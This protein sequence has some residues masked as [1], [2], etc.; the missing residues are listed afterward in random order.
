MH[1]VGM[2]RF[3][4][5]GLFSRCKFIVNESLGYGC[6]RIREIRGGEYDGFRN[7]GDEMKRKVERLDREPKSRG[8]WVWPR[9]PSCNSSD[10]AIV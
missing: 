2:E 7:E 1:I 9:N 4:K 3:T 8:Q 10:R 5:G 6:H